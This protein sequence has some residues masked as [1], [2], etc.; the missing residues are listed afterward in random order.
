MLKRH[1]HG[2]RI[3]RKLSKERK[4]LLENFLPDLRP[5]LPQDKIHPK[6]FFDKGFQEIYFEVGFGDGDMLAAKHVEHPE[7]GFIGCEPFLNGI[8]SLLLSIKD[9][10]T[11]NIRIW[12]DNALTLLDHLEENSLDRLYILNPDP[13]HKKRHWKRRMVN[14]ENLDLFA[15]LLKKDALLIATTDVPE[16]ADWMLEHLQAHDKFEWLS[17]SIEECYEPPRDWVHTAY[18][19]K[20]AKGSSKMV[21]FQFKRR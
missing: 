13:W 11:S 18:E 3:G 15:R 21:Y 16:L 7:I 12:D 19:R 8:S 5:S 20:K 10:D 14:T 17:S 2:R 6:A 1:L 9:H 4:E